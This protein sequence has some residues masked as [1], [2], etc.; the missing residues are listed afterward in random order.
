MGAKRSCS[1]SLFRGGSPNGCTTTTPLCNLPRSCVSARQEK[2]FKKKRGSKPLKANQKPARPKK[3]AA[4]TAST[5]VRPENDLV[6]SVLNAQSFELQQLLNARF[7]IARRCFCFA[8][9]AS[10]KENLSSLFFT[11]CAG[12]QASHF[13]LRFP[14]SSSLSLVSNRLGWMAGSNGLFDEQ[15][16]C[17]GTFPL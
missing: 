4:A 1:H 15:S 17:R 16:H 13:Q 9:R 2:R 8:R 14:A 3:A 5:L 7:G 6:A 11:P 12:P 10:S